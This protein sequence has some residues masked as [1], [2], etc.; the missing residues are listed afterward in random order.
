M[1]C[2]YHDTPVRDRMKL[3]EEGRR[4][5]EQF[6]E[7]LLRYESVQRTGNPSTTPLRRTESLPG[8]VFGSISNM[9]RRSARDEPDVESAASSE[10]SWTTIGIGS[11]AAASCNNHP[12]PST[13]RREVPHHTRQAAAATYVGRN[14][15]Y[16]PPE[17]PFFHP[18]E[19]PSCT[20]GRGWDTSGY[21]P[22]P[23]GP[24]PTPEPVKPDSFHLIRMDLKLNGKSLSSLTEKMTESNVMMTYYKFNEALQDA[25]TIHDNGIRYN[26]FNT[27][28]FIQGQ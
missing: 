11:E 7:S 20:C 28:S 22:G 1:G 19:I 8:R 13:S 5:Q 3:H 23:P 2:P 12:L 15:A 17:R 26:D 10:N 6:E 14:Q 16:L 4:R 27:D 25:N 24:T 21:G 18:V 9:F